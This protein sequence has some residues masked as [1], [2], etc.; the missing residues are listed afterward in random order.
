MSKSDTNKVL[1]LL[2]L[3]AGVFGGLLLAVNRLLTPELISSQTRSDVV[4]VIL[5]ALLILT[6]L[7]WQQIQPRQPDAVKLIGKEGFELLSEL[8]E[9]VK[10]ELA[11]AS[12]LLLTNTVTKTV[13]VWYGG[14]VLLRRGILPPNSQVKFGSILQRVFDKQ[15]PIYLVDLKVY[16]GRIEF[17]YLPENTQ[18][19]I[20][21]PIGNS[22]VMVLGANSP[23]SYTKQDENWIEGIADKLADTLGKKLDNS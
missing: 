23:R 10:T 17:D 18:G 14:R 20:C 11:W 21:Q 15:K 22:G 12:S 6:G 19:V 4:G 9:D 16:P 3:G 1:R 2:P 13:V 5:S 8:P 7:L